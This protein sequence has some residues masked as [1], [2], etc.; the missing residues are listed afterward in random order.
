VPNKKSDIPSRSRSDTY[1]TKFVFVFMLL[2]DP[3]ILKTPLKYF[4]IWVFTLPIGMFINFFG[5]KIFP[6][7]V[8]YEFI[9]K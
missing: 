8:Y 9:K 3:F 2:F 5:N 4:P 1:F 6:R 7:S